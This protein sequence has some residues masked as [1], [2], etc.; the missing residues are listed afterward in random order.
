MSLPTPYYQ[1][2]GIT[3][4]H[5]DCLEVMPGLG[6]VDAVVTDP[7]YRKATLGTGNKNLGGCLDRTNPD[8]RSG[9]LFKH[10]D[11]RFSEWL[12][13]VYSLLNNA[14][15]LYVFCDYSNT[16]SLLNA[17]HGA[18]YQLK[19]CRPMIKRNSAIPNKYGLMDYELIWMFGVGTCRTISDMSNSA[20]VFVDTVYGRIHPTQKPVEA[21]SVLLKDSCPLLGMALDPF[22]GSGTTLVAAK[23][24]GLQAIG[25]EIEER[26]CEIAAKRLAQEVFDFGACDA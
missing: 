5:G 14:T 19:N 16:R 3:I 2:N 18:G 4:Y 15:H 26:Y 10:N 9:K 25:I 7:P 17:A 22:M 24:L 1:H 20:T 8:V 13:A 23:E 12:P 11:C 6:K 21:C